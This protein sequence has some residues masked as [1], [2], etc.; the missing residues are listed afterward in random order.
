MSGLYVL[1]AVAVPVLSAPAV[2]VLS[3]PAVPKKV[4]A[5]APT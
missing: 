5:L 2:P 4:E 1:T 3:A